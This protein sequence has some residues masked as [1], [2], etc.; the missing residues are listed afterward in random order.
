MA[1]VG[2][3]QNITEAHDREATQ[4]AAA[5]RR[6]AAARRAEE[7][8]EAQE[9]VPTP[10]TA[11]MAAKERSDSRWRSCNGPRVA[12]IVDR[13]QKQEGARKAKQIVEMRR[14]KLA[15][16]LPGEL[17]KAASREVG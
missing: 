4:R 16:P 6:E 1:F 17:G 15:V 12:A 14:A 9:K 13:F 7:R 5:Q 10:A 11:R 3:R 2:E 8:L